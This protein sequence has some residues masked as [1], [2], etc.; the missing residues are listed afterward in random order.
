[1]LDK[2]ASSITVDTKGVMRKVLY[3]SDTKFVFVYQP[4]RP[5]KLVA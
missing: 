3:S 2:T 1:M 5:L 4:E